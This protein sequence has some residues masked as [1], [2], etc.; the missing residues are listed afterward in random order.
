MSQE[1]RS[2][3][4]LKRQTWDISWA[5]ATCFPVSDLI[6]AW[7]Q[8]WVQR[9]TGPTWANEKTEPGA[10][11]WTAWSY[12]ARKAERTDT[13]CAH[14][15]REW[16]VHGIQCF[17]EDHRR[18]NPLLLDF[19][20]CHGAQHKGRTQ[21]VLGGLLYGNFLPVAQRMNEV[22]RG[23]EDQSEE[24]AR[25]VKASLNWHLQSKVRIYFLF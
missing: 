12:L 1:S 5:F 4:R 9:L 21:W 18:L 8:P 19:S 22:S 13:R 25:Y 2:L 11:Q 3:P 7:G 10:L 20:S 24:S 15:Y 23:K 17:A 6:S 16:H 14:L